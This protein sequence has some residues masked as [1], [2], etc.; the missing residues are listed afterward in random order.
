MPYANLV[1]G[2]EDE[3][4]ALSTRLGLPESDSAAVIARQLAG[5]DYVSPVSAGL[6]VADY[7]GTASIDRL[8]TGR[9]SHER[10]T[11]RTGAACWD[12]SRLGERL[13]L[14]TRGA[15]GAVVATET[16]AW[17]FEAERVPSDQVLDTTGAGDAFLAGFL[18]QLLDA[19]PLEQCVACGQLTARLVIT[20]TGCRLPDS[21]QPDSVVRH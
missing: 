12:W 3:F 14:M 21:F 15:D 13:A 10:F 17:E 9:P 20:Q 6:R 16:E 8:E 5:F 4:R 18:A 7:R 2:N 19:R 11:A 1:V